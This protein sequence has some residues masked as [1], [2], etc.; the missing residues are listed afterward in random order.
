M[1]LENMYGKN[2]CLVYEVYGNIYIYICMYV[3]NSKLYDIRSNHAKA[4]FLLVVCF[5]VNCRSVF[6]AK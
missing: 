6:R 4:S 5:L 1:A 3:Y 2:V